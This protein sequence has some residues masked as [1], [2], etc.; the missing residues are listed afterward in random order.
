MNNAFIITG[1]GVNIV[2]S[3]G[4]TI[5]V[6]KSEPFYPRVVECLKAQDFDGAKY[7]ALPKP[8]IKQKLEVL[9]G[10]QATLTEDNKV[11]YDGVV[12]DN[13]L[14][15]R[16]VDMRRDGFDVAYMIRFFEN[17]MANPSCRSV[18]E[19][20]GFL[21]KGQMPITEDG[22]FLAYKKVR[23]DYKDIYTGT[24]DNSVGKV[25]EMARNQVDDNS[26]RTCSTG[27]HF[28][29]R[30]YLGSY[31]VNPSSRTMV[32]KINPRDVVSI[33]KDYNETKGRCCRYEVVGEVN[34]GE[35]IEGLV[36]TEF[37]PPA[38]EVPA[39]PSG[40]K[41][42]DILN[43]GGVL[44]VYTEDGWQD[45][46]IV[47][48]AKMLIK[49]KRYAAL[50][51]LINGPTFISLSNSELVE[52]RNMLDPHKPIIRYDSAN[53]GRERVTKLLRKLVKDYEQ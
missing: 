27:L 33:P 23:V 8:A 31:G 29:S 14:T 37:S 28:C 35:K 6:A 36:N 38:P 15:T 49:K 21:E 43:V 48:I 46:T 22:H 4:E 30:D 9:S 3:S 25:I 17:L 51:E 2:F 41:V 19:L 39:D 7:A 5:F 13:T 26:E 12:I 11:L 52:I 40:P 16:I 18:N 53:Q 42:G 47:K 45:A 44:S 32:V 24:I 50:D 20:Y 10:G 1:S 34:A